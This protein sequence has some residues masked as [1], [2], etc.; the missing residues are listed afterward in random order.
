MT[1]EEKKGIENLKANIKIFNFP[2]DKIILKII[3]KQQKEID[4]L[5]KDKNIL[6]GVIDEL[7][8]EKDE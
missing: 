8:G 4:K 2:E 7:K 6:Y 3:E 1:E 5:K